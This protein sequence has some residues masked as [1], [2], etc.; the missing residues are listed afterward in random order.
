[1]TLKKLG[2]AVLVAVGFF[3]VAFRASAQ[4]VGYM[5]VVG[6]QGV[7]AGESKDPAYTGW[8]IIEGANAPTLQRAMA[9]SAADT[10]AAQ[11]VTT[12]REASS[13]MATGRTA[14][15]ATS[16]A[17]SA[18][19]SREAST[20]MATGRTPAPATT[21][22]TVAPRDLS[23]GMASGKRMHKPITITAEMDKATPT[24]QK[25]VASGEAISQVE[26]VMCRKAGG[27]QVVT[28]HYVLTN[29][30]VSSIQAAGAGASSGGE[31]PMESVSF[32]Y[33][34]I[35]MK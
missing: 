17:S 13:G 25:M 16:P 35:E 22:S 11:S 23:T 3:A 26:I 4:E 34:K 33:Q 15:P 14:A 19:T 27:T 7:V 2:V 6:P 5:R 8:I 29:V 18:T 10:A 30:M 31:R 1:M 12:A 28:G 21:S 20:G 32:T 24:L 9:S